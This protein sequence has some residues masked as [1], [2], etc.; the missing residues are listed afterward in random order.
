MKIHCLILLSLLSFA[1][2]A[3]D[4]TAH[5]P[6]EKVVPYQRHSVM[7][8]VS[9]GFIDFHR[10]DFALPVGFEKNNTS[11]YGLFYGKLEYAV[12]DKISIAAAFGYDAFIYNYSQL[13]T[14]YTGPIKRY[15]T[16]HYRVFNAGAIAYYHLGKKIHVKNL[17]PFVGVGFYLN[18]IRHSALAE[19][20]STVVSLRHNGT[21]Y[22]KVGARYYIT[23]RFSLFGDLGYDQQSIFSIGASCRFLPKKESK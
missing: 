11:G 3:Q 8:T 9:A 16:D 5:L 18:N 10:Q 22:I 7:A 4:T 14:G 19:G 6:A 15:K 23:N 13:Y 20:D 12:S 1:A 17:D 2:R 21:P